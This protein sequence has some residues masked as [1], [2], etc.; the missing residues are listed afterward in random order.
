MTNGEI[1]LIEFGDHS[2][3]FKYVDFPFVRGA[4]GAQLLKTNQ[5]ELI[6]KF[7]YFYLQNIEVYN[8]GKYERHFK[9][10]KTEQITLPPLDVQKSIIAE[11]EKVDAD[12]ANAQ[13]QIED[14]KAEINQGVSRGLE[15]ANAISSNIVRLGD[16]CQVN[17]P[18]SGL[19]NISDDTVVSFVE[20][21]SV[22]NDGFIFHK[23]DKILSELKK[24][25][26]TY[27]AEND[28]LIAK[29]TPC[30]ENGKC[31]VA[32]NL[33][34][35]IGMGSSEFHVL[36]TT[37]KIINKYLFAYLNR[38]AIRIEAAKRMT[39][40]SGHRRVPISFYEDLQ[41]PL[42]SLTEQQKIVS[43]VQALEQKI[44]AAKNV[45]AT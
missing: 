34:N 32:E 13:K 4:D 27:F 38:E 24:G 40:A 36:R 41:I 43:Q 8:S 2:C 11:C 26:Y 19:K 29:I 6:A 14:A 21:A 16:V 28:I 33:T 1:W 39:G 22:S 25:S 18:K 3:T 23:E 7:L 35:G 45:F 37:E 44:S 30:M 10:L 15:I 9:Y 17:P 42:P 20:M 31:A 12:F 5:Q